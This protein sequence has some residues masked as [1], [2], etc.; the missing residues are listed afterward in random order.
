MHVVFSH[1]LQEGEP[2]VDD[3][4]SITNDQGRPVRRFSSEGGGGGGC[5]YLIKGTNQ[6]WLTICS[7]MHVSM[8][9]S[10]LFTCTHK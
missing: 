8:V 4:A 1:S 3:N 7:I 9:E 6:H 2:E 5:S 10:I